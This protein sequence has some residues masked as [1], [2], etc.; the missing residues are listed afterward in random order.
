MAI[1][2]GEMATRQMGV[3]THQVFDHVAL[4]R[5]VTKYAE[6]LN[7]KRAAQQLAK[8]LDIALSYPAGPVFLNVPADYNRDEATDEEPTKPAVRA[9][10]AL[11]DAS[12]ADLRATLSEALRPIALAGRGALLGNTPAAFKKFVEAWHLPFFTSYKAKGITGDQ[13]P[14]CLGSV[15]LSPVVDALGQADVH[16]VCHRG[17]DPQ[18][19][20]LPQPALEGH[21]ICHSAS[22]ARF[23]VGQMP[24]QRANEEFRHAVDV[25]VGQGGP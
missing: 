13:H 16:E 20:H 25:P 11:T 19:R 1:L 2:C 18:T 9:L 24:S 21:A 3:Y 15:G 4:A 7:P 22:P 23:V 12:A 6:H 14:L 8:A 5:P 10:T 17:K